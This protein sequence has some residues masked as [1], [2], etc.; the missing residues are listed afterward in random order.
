MFR[1][2]KLGAV[3][4]AACVFVQTPVL[5][6]QSAPAKPAVEKKI[7]KS[8]IPTGSIMPKRI[9]HTRDEWAQIEGRSRSDLDRARDSDRSRSLVSGSR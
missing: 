6:M 3:S 4:L 9:C 2:L 8:E 7:C 5:A 1:G